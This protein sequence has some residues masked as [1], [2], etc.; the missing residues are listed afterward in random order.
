MLDFYADWCTYCK[1]FDDY[2]FS[3][4]KVQQ[5]LSNT[6][7]IQ[8]DITRDDAQDVA[9]KNHVKVITAPA[10]LFFGTDGKEARSNRVLGFMKAEQFLERVNKSFH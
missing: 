8:A 5:A 4:P 1:Q 7:L 3:E 6:V 9:L 10:I 2:V